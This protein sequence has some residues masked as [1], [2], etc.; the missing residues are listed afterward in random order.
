LREK[1]RDIPPLHRWPRSS[2]LGAHDARERPGDNEEE[3]VLVIRG[4]LLKRYPNAVIYA[5]RAEWARTGGRIDPSVERH[6]IEIGEAEEADP[7]RSKLRTPLYEAKIEPDIYFFGFDLTVPEAKGDTGDQPNDAAGWFFV[8]KERPGEPR[9]GFDEKSADP[10]V[11]WNDL[12]WDRVPMAGA[13]ARPTSP[14]IGIP[15]SAPADQQEKEP[16]RV[17][18]ANV[19]WDATVS[20][21]ELAYILYQ[22]PV[23]VAIHAAEMLPNA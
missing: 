21:A 2:A 3:V 20:A 6:L 14:N 19:P 17:D 5:Q 9:F 10:L 15:A 11:V 12:G 8:L 4:E 18:D 23:M 16:Q 22:A 13:F 1:L 7:P